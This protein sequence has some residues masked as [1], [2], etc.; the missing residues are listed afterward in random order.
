ML[1]AE[2]SLLSPVNLF[3]TVHFNDDRQRQRIVMVPAMVDTPSNPAASMAVPGHRGV[4]PEVLISAHEFLAFQCS[5]SHMIDSR[6]RDRVKFLELAHEM[7]EQ[8]VQ[9]ENQPLYGIDPYARDAV[10]RNRTKLTE[11][12]SVFL[13]DHG[14][15]IE[16]PT[17][18]LKIVYPYAE[19][20]PIFFPYGLG[21]FDTASRVVPVS[22]SEF[23]VHYL[24][25]A[26]KELAEFTPFVFHSLYRIETSRATASVHAHHGYSGQVGPAG[27]I[28]ANPGSKF[29]LS[30]LTGSSSYYDKIHKDLQAQC[31]ALGNPDFFYSFTNSNQW[32]VLIAS[33][34]SQD[35]YDVYHKDDEPPCTEEQD[36][37]SP[38]FAHL[39][40]SS[41]VENCHFHSSK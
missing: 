17:N 18:F 29:R 23:V 14:E 33:A 34:L 37:G 27:L 20:A 39:P 30:K 38:Y 25:Y 24:R 2:N 22:E 4:R 9:L 3:N 13:P 6:E 15:R 36:T 5:N 31:D 35:G 19:S 12:R 1:Q 21:D 32:D 26:R 10:E 11:V 28:V 40:C 16:N 41:N 8:Q 7:V